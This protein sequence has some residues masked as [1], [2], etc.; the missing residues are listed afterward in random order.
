MNEKPAGAACLKCPLRLAPCV[1]T[2]FHAGAKLAVVGEHP[3]QDEVLDKRPFVGRAGQFL[4]NTLMKLGVKRTDCVL[5]KAVLCHSSNKDHL[6]EAAKHCR[7]RLHEELAASGVRCV[8]AAGSGALKPILRPRKAGIKE[9]RGSISAVKW[10]RDAK[11]QLHAQDVTQEA[12]RGVLPA[13]AAYIFPIMHPGFITHGAEEWG[14]IFKLDVE[15]AVKYLHKDWLSPEHEPGRTLITCDKDID[16]LELLK[17]EVIA[18]DVETTMAPSAMQAKLLCTV[19]ADR[20]TSVVIPW[21]TD[22][23]GLHNWWKEPRA[24]AQAIEARIKKHT[25][26]GHNL[27]FD[28]PVYAMHGMHFDKF[29]DTILAQHVLASH[30]P[31][32]LRHVASTYLDV[33]QWKMFE[34]RGDIGLLHD[35]NARDGVYSILTWHAMKEQLDA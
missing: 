1:P 4:G 2:E 19:F 25:I 21:T 34:N 18:A 32:N 23:L 11:N 22:M 17:E 6:R 16:A 5:T 10:S 7:R 28:L 3:G 31:K 14:D 30:F 35:Y 12:A 9:W 15:R 20:K 33:A 8:I 29:E 24:I 27:S 26:V 13:G